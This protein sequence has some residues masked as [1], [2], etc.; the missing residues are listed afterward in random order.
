MVRFDMKIINAG[1]LM[2]DGSQIAPLWA[3]KELGVQG[4]SVVFFTGAMSVKRDALVD[5]R[6]FIEHNI[7]VPISSD[8]ALHFIIEHFDNPCLRL[9]Y[10]RQRILINIVKEKIIDAGGVQIK[11]EISDIYLDDK[12]L[13]V[14]VATASSGSSKIHLGLNISSTGAPDGVKIVGLE[15]LGIIDPVMLANDIAQDYIKEISAIDN[16][17]SK[18]RVF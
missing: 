4:D 8:N 11:R 17:I 16:D 13:S 15:E 7:E 10:H 18:T 5:V 1:E 6:D 12:K 2:Y 3:L 9:C 14:S